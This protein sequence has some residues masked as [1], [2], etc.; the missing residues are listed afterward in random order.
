MTEWTAL[1]V[2]GQLGAA[3]WTLT[4]LLCWTAATSAY[5]ASEEEVRQRGTLRWGGD[6]EGG[7]PYVYPSPSNP[8]EI[9]GFE[10]ELARLLAARLGV[11]A[12]FVQGQWDKLPELLNRG[13]IDVVLNGYEWTPAL[14]D[15]YACTIP[16]YV[17]ELQFLVRTN[18][19]RFT[20]LSDLDRIS[21]PRPR[22]AVLGGSAA[23]AFLRQRFA[24]RVDL[25]LYEGN[26][27]AM[28][29]VELAIDNVDATL[30]DLPIVVHYEKRFP[31]LRRLGQP[32]APGFYVMLAQPDDPSLVKALNRA[33]LDCHL[34]S[35]L[36]NLLN[37]YGLWNETQR[38]RGLSVNQSG[39][40]SPNPGQATAPVPH[41]DS[42]RF[43]RM[44]PLL[45]RAAGTTVLLSVVSMPI[46]I[47]LGLIIAIGR[48][49]GPRWLAGALTCYVELIRGTPLVLQ[50]YLIFFV[51]PEIG[52]SL[53]PLFAAITGLA[54]NYSAYE[55]EIYRSGI[56][57]V[58]PGQME[59]ALALGMSRARAI[60]RIILPQAVRIVIPPVTNDF[61]A[62]FKDTAVC[63]VITV[64]EL[65]KAYYIHARSTG[66][67][68][69][70]G[71][72]T[73]ALYLAM[74]YPLAVLTAYV[75]QRM[76]VQ[77]R[78]A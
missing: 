42:N 8:E 66:D 16:Y 44:L 24:E 65:S 54:V 25:L 29:A 15:R 35:S 52:F 17:Y 21:D 70:L 2:L 68:L 73:A 57:A 67:V 62:L 63:S 45:L 7:G 49:Y 69:Q 47:L 9:E 59:A 3:R 31:G 34:D 39:N 64:V 23:E 71:L 38:L 48:L 77:T 20:S 11:V 28:R 18:D 27:D 6:L 76:G 40:F 22:L 78:H 10:V 30:Q 50:L 72:I 5:A 14:A 58:P 19:R 55:A 43:W 36:P 53:P 60:R 26:T 4:W 74:S 61:I 51:L 12:E 33:I 32:V 37:K 41:N 1:T 75:E 46:A 56:Q 13:D